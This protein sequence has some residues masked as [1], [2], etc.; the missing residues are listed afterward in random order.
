MS[1]KAEQLRTFCMVAKYRS[2]TQ[3]AKALGMSQPAVSRQLVHLQEA[4]GKQLYARTATGVELTLFGEELLA[5]ACAVAQ[6]LTR[7]Q[8]FLQGEQR[9]E[10]VVVRIGLS[11]HLVPAYTGRILKRLRAATTSGADLHVHFTEGYSQQLVY[12]VTRRNL[13]AA[14]VFGSDEDTPETLV[15]RRTSEELLCLLVKPDDPLATDAYV[16]SN[17]LQGETLILPASV[18]W[19]YRRLQSYLEAVRVTPGRLIEVSGPYAVRCA[20]LDGL[21][22]GVTARSF[23]RHEVEAKLLRTVGFEASGFVAG[24]QY[25]TR[26]PETYTA[27]IR[28]ALADLVG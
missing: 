25:V 7:A 17:V 4:V 3:A 22:I 15:A 27:A 23:V 19:V 18:S 5:H 2:V 13:D 26:E 12:D 20:V 14:L 1:I 6:T 9:E 11:H 10:R 8:N 28:K 24:I 16:P 21:G